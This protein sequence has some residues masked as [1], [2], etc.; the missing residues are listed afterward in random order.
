MDGSRCHYLVRRYIGLG[1]GPGD[2]VLDGDPAPSAER[3]TATPTFRSMSLVVKRSPISTTVPSSYWL[4]FRPTLP[5]VKR[6][7]L[8]MKYRYHCA[9]CAACTFRLS[10]C[11]G[12][13]PSSPQ[14][15]PVYTHDHSLL[16]VIME[17]LYGSCFHH[18]SPGG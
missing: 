6:R 15:T 17:Y 4:G 18:T 2:S 11:W 14:C 12:P 16:A 1:P 7:H 13:A 3:G 5:I 10:D 9:Y 8:R